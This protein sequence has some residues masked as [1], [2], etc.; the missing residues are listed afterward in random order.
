MAAWGALW[1]NRNS[2]SW[3]EK[4]PRSTAGSAV[5][6]ACDLRQVTFPLLTN[7]CPTGFPGMPQGSQETRESAEL[8]KKLKT[9]PITRY[10]GKTWNDLGALTSQ[11][12]CVWPGSLVERQ[13][14]WR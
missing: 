12:W 9:P 10:Y 14:P 8:C 5:T 3:Q 1:G 2:P 6:L 11:L 7:K 13:A 4:P